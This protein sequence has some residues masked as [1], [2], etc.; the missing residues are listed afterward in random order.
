MPFIQKRHF[1]LPFIQAPLSQ[2]VYTTLYF[3]PLRSFR[4]SQ[5]PLRIP[6]IRSDNNL[7]TDKLGLGA[8]EKSSAHVCTFFIRKY[9]KKFAKKNQKNLWFRILLNITKGGCQG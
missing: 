6:L 2:N 8:E 4:K 1:L 5:R 9:F 3:C 7:F